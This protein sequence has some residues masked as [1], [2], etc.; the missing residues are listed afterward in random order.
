[1]VRLESAAVDSFHSMCFRRFLSKVIG[2][3]QSSI[4]DYGAFQKPGCQRSRKQSNLIASDETLI[5]HL[6]SLKKNRTLL[7]NLGVYVFTDGNLTAEKHRIA[8]GTVL[9]VCAVNKG[10]WLNESL[11]PDC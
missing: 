8:H 11:L 1:M 3:R 5:P 4:I 6:F 9:H 2:R 10:S 7:V